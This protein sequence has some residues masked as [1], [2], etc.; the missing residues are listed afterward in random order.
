MIC[1]FILFVLIFRL[2][3]EELNGFRSKAEEFDR[4]Y[5]EVQTQTEAL[6]KESEE[7]QS[8]LTQL[9]ETIDR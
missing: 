2:T 7:S 5:T 3:Q 1:L 4:K 9:Q 8:K 6:I